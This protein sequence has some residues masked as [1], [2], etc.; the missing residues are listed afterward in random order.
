[1]GNI[2]CNRPIVLH[3]IKKPKKYLTKQSLK[4]NP[5]IY[6]FSKLTDFKKKYEFVSMI[7]FGGFGRV[8]LYRD[9]TFKDLKY[10]IKT[11]KKNYFNANSIRNLLEEVK[12]LGRLDHPN[13]V[14]YF[15]T[16]EDDLYLHIVMEYIPGDNLLRVIT[17]RK[18]NN[19][20]EKDAAE[21]LKCLLRTISFIHQNNIIHRDL[22]PENI[23]FSI[24]GNLQN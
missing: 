12:N 5:V 4:H 18:I 13:I 9:K 23:L 7:G 8:R 11:L 14:K 1:M 21:I 24:S 19:F 2:C 6:Q 17:E 22:K 16:Y 3:E 15:E 10:A 20:R